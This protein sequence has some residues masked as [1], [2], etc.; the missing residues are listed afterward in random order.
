MTCFD[1]LL[2]KKALT[3]GELDLRIKNMCCSSNGYVLT[4]LQ[5][6]IEILM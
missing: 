6:C 3:I 1:T 4:Y 2:V 5:L